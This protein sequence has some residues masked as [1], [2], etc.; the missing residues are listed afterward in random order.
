ME[1]FPGD[2][3]IIHWLLMCCTLISVKTTHD[4]SDTSCAWH[5][6]SAPRPRFVG[7]APVWS[8]LLARA[9]LLRLSPVWLAW[10]EL[11]GELVEDLEL[12]SFG[13]VA[14]ASSMHCKVSLMS[15]YPRVCPQWGQWVC[16]VNLCHLCWSKSNVKLQLKVQYPIE[17]C[18]PICVFIAN[19]YMVAFACD[20]WR[21]V[22]VC[23]TI[24]H[25]LCYI[26]YWK[27][28]AVILTTACCHF[29][30]WFESDVSFFWTWWCSAQYSHLECLLCFKRHVYL[31]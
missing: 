24:T 5:C 15:R 2:Y 14:I 11:L 19:D 30:Y 1:G 17:P 25:S 21:T 6:S 13:W 29:Q 23:V 27:M 8:T 18:C 4:E 26:I 3:Y 22:F 28:L 20:I 7:W 10:T 12:D 16:S 31:V 9:S